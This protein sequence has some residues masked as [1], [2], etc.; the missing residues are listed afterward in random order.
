MEYNFLVGSDMDYTLLMPGQPISDVN[1][2]AARALRAAGGALTI[3]TGR[4]SFITGI[5]TDVLETEVPII[6]SN[7][8]SVFDPVSRKEIYSSLIPDETVKRLLKL[9]I[10]NNSNATCYSPDGI[11]YAPGSLRREFITNYNRDLPDEKKAPVGELTAEM[12][13]TGLPPINKFLLIDPDDATLNEV[14]KVEGLEI[15]SSAGGFYDIMK[16]GNTKGDGLLRVADILGIP[17][18][19]TFAIGDSENDLSMIV[20]AQYGIAMSNSDPRLLKKASY[21]TGTCEE[22]GFAKAVFEYILPLIERS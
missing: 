15:V 7:G 8:A 5:Y 19:K 17:H 16:E 12:L 20:S 22:D 18:E 13:I 6:T 4:S 11:Y 9:F 14:K 21:I 10:D 3:S 2:R 1:L